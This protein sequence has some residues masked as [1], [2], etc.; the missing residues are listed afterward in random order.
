MTTNTSID[1]GST[2]ITTLG[3]ITTGTWNGTAVDVSHGGTG[4][5]T[6]TAYSVIC[7]GTTGTGIF[8]NVSGVGSSAQVLTSNGAAAL[9]TWQTPAFGVLPWTDQSTTSVTMTVNNA[10][11]ADNASLV[12]L[13]LPSTAAFGSVFQIVGKGAGGWKIGQAASQL[14]HIGNQVT[15]TGT[16]GSLASSNQ[17]DSVQLVCVTANTTFVVFSSMGNITYV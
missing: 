4:N 5:T 7:A 12:T 13:T 15:T 16:G 8:Q 6:F 11:V 17:W 3:T 1:I 9:P 2:T 10:Y 14:I